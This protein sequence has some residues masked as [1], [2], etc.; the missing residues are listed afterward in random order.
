M[1][2]TYIRRPGATG[3]GEQAELRL[4]L[5]WLVGASEG[6]LSLFFLLAASKMG[7]QLELVPFLSIASGEPLSSTPFDDA[8]FLF[9]HFCRPL[10]PWG[11]FLPVRNQ[12]APV[13][14]RRALVDEG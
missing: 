6:G 13:N 14:A 7:G 2:R 8:P 10:V 5:A 9:C 3:G 1:Y 4:P 12:Q 11:F